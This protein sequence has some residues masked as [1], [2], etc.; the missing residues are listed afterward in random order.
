VREDEVMPL[1][2]EEQRILREIEANLTATDPA[3]VQQVS[4]TT[5]YRHAARSIKWALVGFV[6]GLALMLVTFWRMLPLGVAGFLT[7][8]VSLLVIERNVRK[9]GRAG[10][11]QVTRSLPGGSFRQFCGGMA[12][13]WRP[14]WRRADA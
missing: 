11:E 3:L 5:L 14:R 10:L 6:G 12:E 13:R 9:L 2:P 1:S 4:E 7:M 8:L